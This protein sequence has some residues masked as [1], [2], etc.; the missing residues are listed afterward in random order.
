MSCALLELGVRQICFGVIAAI[1]IY[2]QTRW[3]WLSAELLIYHLPLT[4]M[5]NTFHEKCRSLPFIQNVLIGNYR[6]FQ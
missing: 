5:R 3:L 6:P 2:S 1:H 4:N